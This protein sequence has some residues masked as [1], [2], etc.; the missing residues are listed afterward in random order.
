MVLVLLRRLRDN[1]FAVLQNGTGGG[2][3]GQRPSAT[4]NKWEND[5][6]GYISPM[7]A[8]ASIGRIM[9]NEWV[10]FPHACYMQV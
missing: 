10:Q 4:A 6:S 2:I 3:R 9:D 8:I 1:H 7:L 5:T